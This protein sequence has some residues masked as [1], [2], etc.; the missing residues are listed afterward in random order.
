MR[1]AQRF[2]DF[3]NLYMRSKERP[4]PEEKRV[5]EALERFFARVDDA[6]Q[7]AEAARQA[8]D[9]LTRL[10]VPQRLDRQEAAP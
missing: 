9:E 1:K 8:K 3:H 2:R 4:Q 6:V 10:T 7:A 5:R